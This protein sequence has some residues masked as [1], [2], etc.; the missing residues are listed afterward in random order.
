MEA[1]EV[2]SLRRVTAHVVEK[3][4]IINETETE[5]QRERACRV[6]VKGRPGMKAGV[7]CGH[8]EV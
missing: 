5:R 7:A 3:L 2:P 1:E 6:R 4:V 8:I